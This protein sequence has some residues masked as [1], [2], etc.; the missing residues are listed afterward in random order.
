MTSKEE[1]VTKV[2]AAIDV[3]RPF[4]QN[5]GGDISLVEV[6]DDNTVRVKL[7]GACGS[8]PYSLMTLKNGVEQAIMRDVPEIRGVEAVNLNIP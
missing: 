2:A 8:C 7:H 3:I 4:L 6:T 5:D 1:I